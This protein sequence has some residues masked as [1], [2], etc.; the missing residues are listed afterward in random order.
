MIIPKIYFLCMKNHIIYIYN[1]HAHKYI[2]L[3]NFKKKIAD[4]HI[5]IGHWKKDNGLNLKEK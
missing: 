3:Q 2:T 5:I 1:L 4:L